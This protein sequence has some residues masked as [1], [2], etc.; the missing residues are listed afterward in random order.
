M[1][2]RWLVVACALAMGC[3]RP[4]PSPSS[5]LSEFVVADDRLASIIAALDGVLAEP[6]Q[7]AGL[8]WNGVNPNGRRSGVSLYVIDAARMKARVCAGP[9]FSRDACTTADLVEGT[10]AALDSETIACDAPFLVLCWS[11]AGAETDEVDLWDPVWRASSQGDTAT[12]DAMIARIRAGNEERWKTYFENTL[13]PASDDLMSLATDLIRRG[14]ADVAWRR[15]TRTIFEGFME[16]V[17][18]HELGHVVLHHLRHGAIEIA[19]L[20]GAVWTPESGPEVEADAYAFRLF[21]PAVKQ[22]EELVASGESLEEAA[23]G[24][25]TMAAPN[26]LLDLD[27]YFNWTIMH[28]L[29]SRPH[30]ATAKDKVQFMTAFF[31]LG[32]KRAYPAMAIRALGFM[33]SPLWEG[34]LGENVRDTIEHGANNYRFICR[35]GQRR[36]D[37]LARGQAVDTRPPRFITV[38]PPTVRVVHRGS[39]DGT[40]LRYRFT[41]GSRHTARRERTSEK[42]SYVG[43]Q[44]QSQR[45]H[46]QARLS[47]DVQHADVHGSEIRL[48]IADIESDTPGFE[49]EAKKI[50][51]AE[52]IY[53]F[54]NRGGVYVE[55]IDPGVGDEVAEILDKAPEAVLGLI[56]LPEEAVAVGDSW[57]VSARMSLLAPLVSARL[58]QAFDL[59]LRSTTTYTLVAR[60]GDTI[61]LEGKSRAEL[62]SGAEPLLHANWE[63]GG[64]PKLTIDLRK[65]FPIAATNRRSYNLNGEIEGQVVRSTTDYDETIDAEP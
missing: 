42:T 2:S 19:Q 21:V 38:N 39:A 41:A 24:S 15:H 37:Q 12:A 52:I 44:I 4:I 54:D 60:D 25:H 17:L 62:L 6:V 48:R 51:G 58:Q 59:K 11:F 53:N 36:R 55:E 7:Q 57:D 27:R 26:I 31:E 47:A 13:V 30:D 40:P 14:D 46:V 10:C 50:A 16:F 64:D 5:P 56:V 29:G 35:W 33:K 49:D 18:W 20:A 23:R 9:G 43:Y 32:C 8:R 65:P 28:R 61:V 3:P 63:S 34:A 22:I 45:I 1:R